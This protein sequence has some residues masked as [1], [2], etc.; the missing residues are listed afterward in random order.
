MIPY[1]DLKRLNAPFTDQ[2]RAKFN[3][4]IDKG[5]YILG[6]E[7]ALFEKQFATYHSLPYCVGISNGL[8]ALI[9]SLKVCELPSGSEVIVPANTF[10]ATILAVLQCGLTPVLVEPDIRTYNIDP[11]KIEEAITP[12]TKAIIAV[13]LYGKCCDMDEI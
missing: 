8:D 12:N 9:L 3:S 10:I 5:Y 6:N 2:L 11:S 1:E 7:V 4:V 13:H